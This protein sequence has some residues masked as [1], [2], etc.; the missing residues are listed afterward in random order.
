MSFE[1]KKLPWW[2]NVVIGVAII[3]AG[4]FL[5]VSPDDGND[6]LTFAVG[7]GVFV[8]FVY[9]V[10]KAVQHKRDNR[11]FIPYLAHG[12][13]DLI[14]FILII[15]IPS[16]RPGDSGSEASQ[17]IGIIIA[18]WLIIFGFFEIVRKKPEVPGTHFVRNGLLLILSGTVVMSILLLTQLNYVIFIGIVAIMIGVVKTVQG[19]LGK[20]RENDQA[21]G[22]RPGLF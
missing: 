20:A 17:L 18:C 19:F 12:L 4:I 8:F 16:T 7:L 3:T 6:F 5:L 10:I 15:S 9:N 2:L 11:L 1:G 13:L 22:G 21:S 14:L